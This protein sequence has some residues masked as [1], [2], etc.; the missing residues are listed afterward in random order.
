[1]HLYEEELLKN[2]C[3]ILPGI[4]TTVAIPMLQYPV[5]GQ[6]GLATCMQ[7]RILSNSPGS[8][9]IAG[10]HEGRHSGILTLSFP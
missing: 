8:G 7:L 4:I 10:L 5:L 6:L 1:M 9:G 2:L 3:G